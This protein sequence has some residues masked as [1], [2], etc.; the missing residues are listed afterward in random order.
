MSSE[1]Q[2]L[3]LIATAPDIAVAIK[4]Y[5][6]LKHVPL[7]ANLQ[8]LKQTALT[9]SNSP[10]TIPQRNS[11]FFWKLVAANTRKGDEILAELCLLLSAQYHSFIVDPEGSIK[12]QAP[13]HGI[14]VGIDAFTLESNFQTV[15]LSIINA[16]EQILD[17]SGFCFKNTEAD[18]IGMRIAAACWR[19]VHVAASIYARFMNPGVSA[20]VLLDLIR[21]CGHWG[22]TNGLKRTLVSILESNPSF[23]SIWILDSISF[24]NRLRT[25]GRYQGDVAILECLSRVYTARN[26]PLLI[27]IINDLVKVGVFFIIEARI[28]AT[29]DDLQ[30]QP[31]LVNH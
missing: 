30:T 23:D 21:K 24:Q 4:A 19:S 8:S 12:N 14:L 2:L 17:P 5:E 20:P 26:D 9:L 7:A 13:L 10:R 27:R 11:Q 25:D 18:I 1:S 6:T 16:C 31:P 3:D 15:P 28:S 22:L 29:V